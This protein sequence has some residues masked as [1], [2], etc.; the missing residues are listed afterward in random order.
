MPKSKKPDAAVAVVKTS[1]VGA[2]VIDADDTTR[3]L[4]AVERYTQANTANSKIAG[5]T[6][7]RLSRIEFTS[8]R[9]KS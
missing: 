9:S 5:E 4:A 2:R 3:F 1:T 7:D 6:I 8:R